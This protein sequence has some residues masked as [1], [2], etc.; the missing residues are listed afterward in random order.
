LLPAF[1][2]VFIPLQRTP[3]RLLWSPAQAVHQAANMVRVI[4]HAKLTLDHLGYARCGPQIGPVALRH[5]SLEQKADKS[6]SL[7]SSQFQW[8]PGRKAHLQCVHPAASARIS[9]THHR[10]WIASDLSSNFIESESI[11]QQRQSA[12][13]PILEKIGAS[14]QSG[15]RE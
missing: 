13:T 14:L 7:G 15:H 12:P 1:D 5:R 3:F 6:L 2:L 4:A 9:P 8:A 10:T 11:I